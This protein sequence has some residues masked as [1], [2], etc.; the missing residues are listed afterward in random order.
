MSALSRELDEALDILSRGGWF[1]GRSESARAAIAGVARLRDYDL[2]QALFLVGDIPNGIFG[3]VRGALDITLPRADGMDLTI[4]RADPGF[5]VGDLAL[6]A[7]EKRL[8]SVVAAGPA[9]VVH[10][11][12]RDLGLLLQQ[13]ASYYA[14]FY[15]LSHE[16]MTTVLRLLGNLAI[17]TSEARVAMRLLLQAETQSG[18]QPDIRLSQGKLAELVALSL[19]TLQRVLRRLEGEGLIKLGYGRIRIID[20]RRLVALCNGSGSV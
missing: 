10:L 16:N 15:A 14:D 3:L 8:V 20:R 6:L 11:Q 5:W 18:S 17:T 9:R 1:A 12:Q 7:N 19:P 2:G 4:H 13:D